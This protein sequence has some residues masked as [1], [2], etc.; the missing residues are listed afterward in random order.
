MKKESVGK[1]RP[2][3]RREVL[4]AGCV[5]L[6][7]GAIERDVCATVIANREDIV[8]AGSQ[9]TIHQTIGVLDTGTGVGVIRTRMRAPGEISRKGMSQ[10]FS[11][12]LVEECQASL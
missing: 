10:E 3:N 5:V 12:A 8:A 7:Q 6:R 9:E 11:A 2:E 1:C 4:I